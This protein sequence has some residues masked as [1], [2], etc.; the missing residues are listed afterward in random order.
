MVEVIVHFDVLERDG[1]TSHLRGLIMAD[2]GEKPTISQVENMLRSMGYQVTA[3]DNEHYVY[4][5][6]E[7]GT[8]V[9]KI[10]VRKMD[11]GEEEFS[12][13]PHMKM[14]VQNLMGKPHR[15]M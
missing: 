5:P 7:A 1:D 10:E 3:E 4:V 13:D 11:N 15:P 6:V 8:E 9:K 2:P 14:I 12:I